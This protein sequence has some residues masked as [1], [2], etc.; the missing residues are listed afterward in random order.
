MNINLE[1][2]VCPICQS[3]QIDPV[4]NLR[5][6]YEFNLPYILNYYHCKNS[7]CGLVFVSPI[8]T[9]DEIIKFYD[10]YA[11]HITNTPVSKLKF[12]AWLS[13]KMDHRKLKSLFRKDSLGSLKVLDYGCGNG[14]LLRKLS[15]LGISNAIGYDLDP[16]ACSCAVD[17]GLQAFSTF[18]SIG[19]NGPYDYIF[20]NHVVEHLP[21]PADEISA[22][23]S[24]V[25]PNGKVIIRTPNSNSFLAQVFKQKWRG[26]ETPRHL[27]IFNIKS[28]EN[29]MDSIDN[30]SIV[31]LS[32]T[33]NMF[34]GIFHESFHSNF[35][36]KTTAGKI[37]RN[38]LFAAAFPISILLNGFI[39]DIGEEL[40]L[41]IKTNKQ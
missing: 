10:V 35:Y 17:Q 40:Y 26:W 20:L 21:H 7:D 23:I 41:I 24:Y 39:R 13:K 1:N 5:P 19:R 34:S 29:L 2:H 14:N 18:D 4:L 28:I 11:T 36:R 12:F 6:D 16:K 38:I 30:V 33:N 27:N 25:K 31:E 9:A 22:L 8:P 37:C 3:R 32:T 15:D